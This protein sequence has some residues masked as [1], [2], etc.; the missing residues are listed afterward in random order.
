MNTN[1]KNNLREK[2]KETTR[3]AILEAA[4]SLIIDPSNDI[5]M[6]DIAEKAGVAIG[7]LYNY[8]KNR[9][10]LIDTIIEKRRKTAESFIC[11]SQEQTRELDV[12]ARLETLFHT[13]ITFLQK[14]R[15]VTHHS[16]QLKET[17]DGEAGGRSM[18]TMLSECMLEILH[19]AL[20]RKEI[21]PEFKDI[22]PLV[23]SGFM[24]EIFA[25]VGEGMDPGNNT[26]FVKNL[27]SLFL[28]GAGTGIKRT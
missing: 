8:F 26:D 20:E 21:R 18:M 9:Q 24:R 2:L 27:V 5:R 16:L 15:T 12:S 17:K 6:E 11:R 25:K 19:T 7:T 14:H 4:V 3:E 1:S 28:T 22:Y 10:M 13:L 23:I